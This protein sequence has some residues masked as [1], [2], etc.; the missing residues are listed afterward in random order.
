MELVYEKLG[1]NLDEKAAEIVVKV[2]L[3]CTNASASLRPTMS[4]V[5]SMLEG[6]M[7]V[8]DVIPEPSSYTN[9]LRFKAMRDLHRERQNQSLSGSQNNDSTTLNTFGSSFMSGKDFHEIKP[10]SMSS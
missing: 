8:P 1:S 4:E 7:T 6:Q 10:E 2:A 5:V 3:L 9:D